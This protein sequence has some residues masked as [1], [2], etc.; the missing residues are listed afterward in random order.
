M[1]CTSLIESRELMDRFTTSG[2]FR[3]NDPINF[4]LAISR[5]IPGCIES[6][7]G[8][9]NYQDYRMVKKNIEGMSTSEFTGE[10]GTLIIGQPLLQRLQQMGGDGT[11]L[12]FLKEKRYQDQAEYRFL[13][14][15]NSRYHNLENYL[16]ISCKEAVEYCE[17]AEELNQ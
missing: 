3:I 8:M 12:M 6:I 17:K 10:E 16:T 1:F 14:R 15:I 13:W 9:C 7:Q 4:S 11:D 5:V 2:Y